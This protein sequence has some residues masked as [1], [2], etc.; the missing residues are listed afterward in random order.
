MSEFTPVIICNAD[1][2]HVSREAYNE[3]SR[4]QWALGLNAGKAIIQNSLREVLTSMA[5]GDEDKLA[6][7]V[8]IYNDV[9]LKV[10]LSTIESFTREFNVVM[11]I[12]GVAI[13]EFT[14]EAE[15]SDSAIELARS[16]F[17]I[18]AEAEIIVNYNGDKRRGLV[19]GYNLM[20]LLEDSIE[21]EVTDY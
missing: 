3:N 18:S 17:T 21:F 5:E 9:M 7:Y 1:D 6:E 4:S 12:N 13:A 14:V 15:D 10:G 16:E 19:E 8:D 2:D 20:E 11:S